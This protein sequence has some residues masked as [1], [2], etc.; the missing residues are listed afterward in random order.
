MTRH[1]A[2]TVEAQF[3]TQKKTGGDILFEDLWR[4]YRQPVED[5]EFDYSIFHNGKYF[6]SARSL[7]RAVEIIKRTRVCE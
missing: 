3:A 4:V 1:G 5:G 6:A 2:D 7:T